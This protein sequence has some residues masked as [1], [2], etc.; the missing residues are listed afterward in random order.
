MLQYSQNALRKISS[1]RT[2]RTILV[3]PLSPT[4]VSHHHN[5]GTQEN[6]P[7]T[8]KSQI[9]ERKW[10]RYDTRCLTK[11]F[12]AITAGGKIPEQEDCLLHKCIARLIILPSCRTEMQFRLPFIYLSDRI[13]LLPLGFG[14][15][16][17]PRGDVSS[18]GALI[19][20]ILRFSI[21]ERKKDLQ[22]LL[23]LATRHITYYPPKAWSVHMPVSALILFL[24]TPIL[25]AA[26]N[27]FAVPRLDSNDTISDGYTR[28]PQITQKVHSKIMPIE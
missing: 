2:T 19:K 12:P 26:M 9:N 18:K 20:R 1:D 22:N 6:Q 17:D 28:Q 13:S 7:T 16:R 11:E 15:Q 27:S 4:I 14:T 5:Q 10:D 24:A 8:T 21:F 25:Y 3:P 23:F